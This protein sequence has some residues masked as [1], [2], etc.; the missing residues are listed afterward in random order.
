M[1]H[2]FDIITINDITLVTKKKD[3][4]VFPLRV[5]DCLGITN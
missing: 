1:L 4:I 2:A 5:W 3:Q